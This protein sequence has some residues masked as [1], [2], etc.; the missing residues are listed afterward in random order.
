VIIKELYA[1]KIIQQTN[2]AVLW[3]SHPHQ[4]IESSQSFV[5]NDKGVCCCCAPPLDA[6][7]FEKGY[8]TTEEL[9]CSAVSEERVCISFAMCIP[10]TILHGTTQPFT[11]YTRNSSRKGA[12]EKATV[13]VGTL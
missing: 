5:S 1:F 2:A 13:V 10:H 3:T 11:P 4:S 12:F 7:S 8:S 6:S 9:V